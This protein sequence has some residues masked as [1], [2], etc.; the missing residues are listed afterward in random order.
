MGLEE[1]RGSMVK[2]LLGAWRPRISARLVRPRCGSGS[3][4]RFNCSWMTSMAPAARGEPL[5]GSETRL[6]QLACCRHIVPRQGLGYQG[7]CAIVPWPTRQLRAGEWHLASPRPAGRWRSG[8]ARKSAPDARDLAP[9]LPVRTR[10]RG[11]PHSE[12]RTPTPARSRALPGGQGGAHS[13]LG[14]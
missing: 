10:A 1:V 6:K 2:G 13:G 11:V 3:R 12:P 5:S 7:R 9:R 4:P 8:S 14:D